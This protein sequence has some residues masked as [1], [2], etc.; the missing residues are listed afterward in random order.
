MF[1][2]F[3]FNMAYL[4]DKSNGCNYFET[5][6]KNSNSNIIKVFLKAE[7]VWVST[8]EI[9]FKVHWTSWKDSHFQGLEYTSN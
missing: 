7:L 4:I 1:L 6:L 8:F 9:F 2:F 3:Q 5:I